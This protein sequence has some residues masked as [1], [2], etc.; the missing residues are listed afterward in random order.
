MYNKSGMDSA[1]QVNNDGNLEGI[2][3]THS[4]IEGIFDPKE[5]LSLE[6][7]PD[8]WDLDLIFPSLQTE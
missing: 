5:V 8:G 6:E 1:Y 7:A 2:T 3:T 4:K